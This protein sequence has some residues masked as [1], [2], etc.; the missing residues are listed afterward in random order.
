[1]NIYNVTKGQ[2]RT[3]LGLC[4]CFAFWGLVLTDSYYSSDIGTFI[5]LI[6]IGFGLFYYLGW[7]SNYKKQHKE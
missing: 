7:R 6:S 4:A 1:M 3:I 2:M 5:L